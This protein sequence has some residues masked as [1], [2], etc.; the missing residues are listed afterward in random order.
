M[1]FL[2]SAHSTH[3]PHEI[4]MDANA[5]TPVLPELQALMSRVYNTHFGNP[6]SPH[7]A[8]IRAKRILSDTRAEAGRLF[9]CASDRILF[10]SG[11]TEGINTA[12]LSVLQLYAGGRG[13]GHLLLYGATEHKAVPEAL[14][15]WNELLRVGAELQAIP[16]NEDGLLDYDF[17]R[18]QVPHAIMIC[19]MG[20]NNETG[21]FA[22]LQQLEQVIRSAAP[23]VPW[24][25]DCVQMLGKRPVALGKTTIDY[26]PFSA[27]KLYGPKGVGAMYVRD[28]APF[29]PLQ[30]GGGQEQGLRGGTENVAGVA[31]LGQIF[32]WLNHPET[33][34]FQDAD[35]LYGYRHEIITALRAAFPGLIVNH[36]LTGSLPT[37]LNFSVA[38]YSSAELIAI[39]DAAGIRVSA[40]SACSTGGTRSFVLDAM[41]LPA[42]QSEGA[43]R[44]SFGPAF[45]QSDLDA[46]VERLTFIR[47]KITGV[48]GW[49]QGALYIPQPLA[50]GMGWILCRST[51]QVLALKEPH[52]V[53]EDIRACCGSSDWQ[54]R[55]WNQTA[56]DFAGFRIEPDAQGIR[57]TALATMR[58]LV[59]TDAGIALTDDIHPIALGVAELHCDHMALIDVRETS[60]ARAQYHQ[61]TESC[62]VSIPRALWCDYLLTAEL[63]DTPEP[64]FFCRS[65][66]R[67][68][69]VA[70][71]ALSVGWPQAAVCTAA[72]SEVFDWIQKPKDP[73][74]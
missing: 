32:A 57:V 63:Q 5:T 64:V 73:D 42:W 22:D 66:R 26:A 53:M 44:M 31:A 47:E 23:Q 8:G 7:Y 50:A 29:T 70:R 68:S 41:G 56:Q 51:Q 15:H 13:K 38:G 33:S 54:L 18:S 4:F 49:G 69:D 21:V 46:L 65:G 19:T 40:G 59:L 61:D 24:L 55:E 60:E 25:V 10:M 34:P 52:S 72:A 62:F 35:T 27:H 3:Y 74:S 14:R 11:A 9:G 12:V 45:S 17:I 16:V 28:G 39:F 48:N 71:L 20:A 6:S 37:T 67:A 43:I 30:T 58:S 2:L 36:P 1:S